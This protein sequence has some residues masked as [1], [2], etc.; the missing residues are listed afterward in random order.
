MMPIMTG[1]HTASSAL[2]IV[3][4]QLGDFDSMEY[5]WWLQ[6]DKALLAQNNIALRVVAIGARG[7]GQKFCDYTGFDPDHL[8][9]DATASLH[10]QLELYPGLQ[11]KLPFLS[12]TQQAWF[13]LLVMCAGIGSPG[14]LKEV[15]RGYTGDKNSPSLFS[16]NETINISPFPSFQGNL[17]DKVGQDYQRPFELATLRL[18]N[19]IE[20]LTNWH[21][22]VED[23][24]YLTQRGAT[25]LFDQNQNLLYQ[26]RDKGILGFAEN[27]S[28]PL[29]FLRNINWVFHR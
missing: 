10:Q 1:C 14:T 4:P 17:F 13:N 18:K 9:V 20:V 6:R 27:M 29:Q 5:A 28:N 11:V 19:M 16:S 21:I 22:Y 8:F 3:L 15:L 23:G 12:P 25:F 2:I 26:H 24:R 7:A